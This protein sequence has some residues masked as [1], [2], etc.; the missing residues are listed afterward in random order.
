M[1]P[2]SQPATLQSISES[3]IAHLSRHLAR[4]QPDFNEPLHLNMSFDY[5]GLDSMSRVELVSELAKQWSVELDLTAAYD[6]ITVG[7]LAQF[8]N[9]ELSRR[10]A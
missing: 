2:S 9:E 7:S 1:N 5:I 10:A 3:I 8:V 4:T 6:F